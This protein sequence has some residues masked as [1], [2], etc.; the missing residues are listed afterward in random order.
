MRRS[1]RSTVVSFVAV[2]ICPL[3]VGSDSFAQAPG[4][5]GPKGPAVAADDLAGFRTLDPAQRL[6]LIDAVGA[7]DAFRPITR[8]DLTATV[9]ERGTLDA[10]TAAELI[11]QLKARGKD[12]AAS[13]IKWVVENGQMVKKG[14]RLLELDDAGLRD[15]TQAAIVRA[16]A[17]SAAATAAAEEVQRARRAGEVTV[18]LAQIEV[19]LAEADR[20]QPP[21]GANKRVLDLKVER[22]QLRLEQVKNEVRGRLSKAEAEGRKLAAAAQ[23]EAARVRALEAE[24]AKCVLTAPLD[25]IAVYYVAEASRFGRVLPAVIAVGELVREGQKLIRVV[26]LGRMVVG[27]RIHESQ[28][29][30]VRV[31]QAVRVRVDAL[32]DQELR[33]K[34]SQVATVATQ[35]EWFRSDVKVYPVTATLDD[36]PRGLK[37]G[38]SAEVRI[39]TGEK[40][41]VLL[42]PARAVRSVGPTRICFVKSEGK[43]IER[44]VTTGATDGDSVEVTAGLEAGDVVLADLT[45]VAGRGRPGK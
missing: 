19:E 6:K 16:H 34:V 5:P 30:T 15:E 1:P 38:M 27:T 37:P 43:L 29:S 45:A 28:I 21:D 33:G 3:T 22:A 12:A 41:G 17:A 14:D 32:P 10:A 42:V 18:R 13:T 23:A 25:G 9:V 35:D 8:G 26:N 40:K 36:A 7:R 20:K 11:C 31:G 44:E 4:G 24:L 39:V 2:L